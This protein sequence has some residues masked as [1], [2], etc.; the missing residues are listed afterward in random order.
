MKK[1]KLQNITFMYNYYIGLL[2]T[3]YRFTGH[4]IS[5]YWARYIGLLGTINGQKKPY[6]PRKYASYDTFA[7]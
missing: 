2:G 6:K 1:R 7:F 3:I 4:D 5:V